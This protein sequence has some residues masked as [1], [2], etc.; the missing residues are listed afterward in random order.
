[1]NG[2]RRLQRCVNWAAG[3]SSSACNTGGARERDRVEAPYALLYDVHG[4]K[5]T[6][7]TMFPTQERLEV[8]GPEERRC[9]GTRQGRVAGQRHRLEVSGRLPGAAAPLARVAS[10]LHRDRVRAAKRPQANRRKA[11]MLA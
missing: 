1:M 10:A 6:R 2:V 5:I 3:S 9:R 4:G 11:C 7:L 8:A